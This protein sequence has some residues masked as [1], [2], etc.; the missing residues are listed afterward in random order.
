MKRKLSILLTGLCAFLFV[1]CT[2]STSDKE[3][4]TN[5][6]SKIGNLKTNPVILELFTSQGCSSC[7]RAD[8]LLEKY[9][10]MENVVAIS[11]HVDYWNR[12]GWKDPFSSAAF[13]L[14][15]QNYSRIFRLNGVYTPQLVINGEREMVGSD[16]NKVEA[17]LKG[18]YNT[19]STAQLVINNVSIEG[20][21]ATIDYSVTKNENKAV[22]NIALIQNKI[23]TSI[24]SGENAGINLTN[25]NV[26]RNFKSVPSSSEST[27]TISIDLVAGVNKEDLSVALFLQD[28]KTLKILA[29]A[30]SS[31]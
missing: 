23:T 26:V 24:K 18:A 20:T 10:D 16:A 5:N 21:K 19:Q 4:A 9:A 3:T 29:G 25:I 2:T 28:P 1:F 7:P 14:R 27:S 30:K 6:K 17:T 31:L 12:L 13:S 11:Y 8:R 15:Q 22:L